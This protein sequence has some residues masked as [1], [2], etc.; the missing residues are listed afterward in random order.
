[1]KH[2]FVLR[3]KVNGSRLNIGLVGVGRLMSAVGTWSFRF[4]L[5]LYILDV[6][7]S[8]SKFALV[9]GLSTLPGIVVN[10]FAGVFADKVDRKKIIVLSDLLSGVLV[11]LLSLG[12]VEG[13][14][15]IFLFSI[16]AILISTLQGFFQITMIAAVPNIVEEKDIATTNSVIQGV[17]GLSNIL[18]P[19][20]GAFLY[21][22]FG[23][24]AVFII[25]GISFILSAF[26][27]YFIRF[28]PVEKKESYSFGQ[29]LK[30]AFLYLNEFPGLKGGVIVFSVINFFL[31][32]IINMGITYISYE[33]FKLSKYQV[34]FIQVSFFVGT[35]GGAI[36]ISAF[37]LAQ[38]LS[39][40][41]FD[42]FKACALVL[43]FWLLIDWSPSIAA[44][45]FWIISIMCGSMLLM[46]FLLMAF[47]IPL[48]T[49][50]QTKIPDE[51]RGSMFGLLAAGTS[52]ATP[53]GM[54]VYGFL[55]EIIDWTYL[56][57][58][59]MAGLIITAVIAQRNKKIQNMIKVDL[60]LK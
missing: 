43:S 44:S 30:R 14:A 12:F 57:L 31:Y 39:S 10:I 53:L 15:N 52:A 13:E 59:T 22:Q 7:G 60:V 56:V 18:G 11:L 37:N 35:I 20:L 34:G 28:K 21:A 55:F 8:A 5:G 51:K 45:P 41:M 32:P 4:A 49:S 33:I 58:F 29:T 2:A 54:W 38:K 16:Y 40:S 19:L 6:T 48:F 42:T 3:N 27:E 46:G 26:I 23:L 47:N 1:M 36:I 17:D 50:L 9:F 24:L 25:D